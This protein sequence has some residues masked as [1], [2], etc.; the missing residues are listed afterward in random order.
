MFI[1]FHCHIAYV[2][3]YSEGQGLC[4]IPSPVHRSQCIVGPQHMLM[5]LSWGGQ[6]ELV[7]KESSRQAKGC[8]VIWIAIW[9]QALPQ[10]ASGLGACMFLINWRSLYTK[11]QKSHEES[12]DWNPA[13]V[14]NLILRRVKREKATNEEGN[15]FMQRK[16]FWSFFLF[17]YLFDKMNL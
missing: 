6:L 7:W 3:I 13:E 2:S 11:R 16:A 5:E 17:P 1:S 4:W 12:K 8:K 15:C 14:L 9:I 10:L